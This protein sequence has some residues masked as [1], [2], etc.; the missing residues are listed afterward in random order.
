MDG[1][2]LFKMDGYSKYCLCYIFNC[3]NNLIIIAIEKLG[4]IY[5]ERIFR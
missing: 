5:Y 3:H 1:K 4:G 2:K